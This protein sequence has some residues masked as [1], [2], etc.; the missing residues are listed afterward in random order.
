MSCAWVRWLTNATS[1]LLRMSVTACDTTATS[2]EPARL[3][4]GLGLEVSDVSAASRR[5]LTMRP[6]SVSTERWF[7]RVALL[8]V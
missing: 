6:C 2:I 8:D 3:A 1:N 4:D 5:S 7:P